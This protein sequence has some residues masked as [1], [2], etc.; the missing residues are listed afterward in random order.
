[1]QSD[2]RDESKRLIMIGIDSMDRRLVHEYLDDLP[3]FRKLIAQSPDVTLNSVFPPDSDT[4]W[5]SIYTGLNPAQHG[6]VN[7]VDPL[8]KSALY[9]TDYLRSTSIRNRTF[10]DIAGKNEKTV[11]I[12]FPHVAYPVWEVNGFIIAPRPKTDEFE[13]Y[14]P[15]YEFNFEV[16]KIEVPRKIPDT[17]LEYRQ[18]LDTFEKIVVNEFNFALNMLDE[19]KWDLFFFYSSILDFIEHVFWNYCDPQDPTYPGDE[20]PFRN[21]IR[22]FYVLHDRLI[23]EIIKK[24]DL[25]TSLIVLSDHG[26]GM[27]PINLYNM[28][29]VL[30][31]SGH[32]KGKEGP[33]SPVY[34]LN[35]KLKRTA[36]NAVQRLGMRKIAMNLLRKHPGIEKMYTVP[37]SIDFERSVAFSSD[38]SGMK[39]YTYGGIFIAR[40]KLAAGDAYAA[41]REDVMRSISA[42][43]NSAVDG[44]VIEWIRPREQLYEG[45]HINK[46]PD[47]LFK[48]R[49]GYG[50]GWAIKLPVFSKTP[51]HNL[52]P[53]SHEG[54]TPILFLHNLGQKKCAIS[55]ATLMDIAPTVLDILGLDSTQLSFDGASIFVPKT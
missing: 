28:N 49:E 54:R 41:V 14:P 16:E 11:C 44:N 24:A 36:V 6:V 46:Y 1:M 2:D 52:F 35:E 43:A 51:A 50:A 42:A 12:L 40:D 18:Y 33:L 38:L 17:K 27:R 26:H 45:P 19:R 5:A 55:E 30:R 48:L 32:L 20:N 23:G 29:E 47:I 53:G 39:S 15:D 7:F 22:D 37:S 31:K 9:Q 34:D 10:W 8:D 21:S 4:A 25:D 13:I 3:T